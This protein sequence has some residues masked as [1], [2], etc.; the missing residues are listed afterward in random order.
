MYQRWCVCVLVCIVIR[1]NIPPPSLVILPPPIGYALR[2]TI[3][4]CMVYMSLGIG[5]ICYT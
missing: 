1:N 2:P 3:V 5:G 4:G